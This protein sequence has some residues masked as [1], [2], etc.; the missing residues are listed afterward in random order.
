MAANISVQRKTNNNIIV[1]LEKNTREIRTSVL[2]ACYCYHQLS[3]AESLTLV[4]AH[5][6][7]RSV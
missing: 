2:T 4:S 5:S 3:I 6:R 7:S 1:N